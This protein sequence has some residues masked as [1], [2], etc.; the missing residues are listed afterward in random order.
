MDFSTLPQ[1]LQDAIPWLTVGTLIVVFALSV[2][3]L[4]TKIFKSSR[5]DKSPPD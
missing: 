2:W 1:L 3:A 5:S 4:G